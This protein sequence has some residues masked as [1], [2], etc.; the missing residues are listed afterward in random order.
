MTI[1]SFV[2]GFKKSPQKGSI[3]GCFRGH[4]FS[5]RIP[6]L[7]GSSRILDLHGI[8]IYLFVL[9]VRGGKMNLLDVTSLRDV[10]SVPAQSVFHEWMGF[11]LNGKFFTACPAIFMETYTDWYSTC[12]ELNLLFY[13][14]HI[15]TLYL[16]LLSDR[17]QRFCA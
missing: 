15:I 2:K 1:W 4:S 8:F 10:D 5:A 3:C 17:Q 7:V 12:L 6:T 11:F 9:L 13:F 14:L 16:E